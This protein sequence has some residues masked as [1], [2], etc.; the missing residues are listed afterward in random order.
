MAMHPALALQWCS[1]ACTCA[2]DG[3]VLAQS[4]PSEE[5]A[6]AEQ[7]GSPAEHFH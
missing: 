4:W 5:A 7:N 2:H 3:M 1:T 6:A